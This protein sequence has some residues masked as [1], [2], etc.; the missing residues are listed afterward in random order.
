MKQK[1]KVSLAVFACGAGFSTLVG[2]IA[3]G[4]TKTALVTLALLI[5][6]VIIFIGVY[7]DE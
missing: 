1:T 7:S 4:N 5:L 6:H 3:R 2:A